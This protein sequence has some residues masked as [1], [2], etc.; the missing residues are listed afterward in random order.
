MI[1]PSPT[2]EL[3]MVDK[4]SLQCMVGD[5]GRDNDS[6]QMKPAMFGGTT[7]AINRV[8]TQVYGPLKRVQDAIAVLLTNCQMNL[9]KIIIGSLHPLALKR[10]GGMTH[11]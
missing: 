4:L 1:S 8:P 11:F 7:D 2:D 3:M 6:R 5:N 10:I 9:S